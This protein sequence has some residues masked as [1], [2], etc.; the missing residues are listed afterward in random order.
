MLGAPLSLPGART[1]LRRAASERA[2]RTCER[3]GVPRTY[4][5]G[6]SERVARRRR[7]IGREAG[8]GVAARR[9]QENDR[10]TREHQIH[11]SKPPGSIRGK[12]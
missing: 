11:L 7:H 4:D 5:C 9:A 8:D 6:A 3:G 2:A 10:L 1:L 12:V